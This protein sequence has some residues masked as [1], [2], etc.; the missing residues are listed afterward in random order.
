MIKLRGLILGLS[1]L[2]L[3]GPVQAADAPVEAFFGVFQGETTFLTATGAKKRGISV[4]FSPAPN[5]MPGI[6]GVE[7][8]WTTLSKRSDG[9]F[10]SKTHDAVFVPADPA[11]TIFVAVSSSGK[12]EDIA[13]LE[14]GA[15]EGKDGGETVEPRS[16]RD[17]RG[18]APYLWGR[19]KENTFSI[20]VVVVA[21]DGGYEIQ[22]YNRT[23]TKEG[24]T[25]VYSRNRAGE[26]LKLLEAFL[27][28]KDS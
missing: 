13:K 10:S 25:L 6:D 11:E 27:K 20:Y 23:L 3:S 24:M 9:S 28:R 16:P 4:S 19:I 18:T 17:P 26:H 14:Q 22:V 12:A 15:G 21:E 7:V 1:L 5:A 8:S 2:I